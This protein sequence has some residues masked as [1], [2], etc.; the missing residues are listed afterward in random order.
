MTEIKVKVFL[1]VK[2]ITNE[3]NYSLKNVLGITFLG[4]PLSECKNA[5]NFCFCFLTHYS[6]SCI[7]KMLDSYYYLW[8]CNLQN[9][10]FGNFLGDPKL[11]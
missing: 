2:Q 7:S 4:K 10:F 3:R 11:S 1:R 8:P 6:S 5:C 9:F